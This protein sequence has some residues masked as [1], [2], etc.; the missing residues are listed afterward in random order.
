MKP[1]GLNFRKEK[2]E[3]CLTSYISFGDL[4]NGLPDNGTPASFP[5]DT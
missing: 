5:A 2:N 3:T 4:S 1:R